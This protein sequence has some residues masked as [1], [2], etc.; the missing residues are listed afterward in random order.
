MHVTQGKVYNGSAV[1]Q[2]EPWACNAAEELLTSNFEGKVH[3]SW[4][5]TPFKC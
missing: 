5:V 4:N 3:M 1:A 2:A